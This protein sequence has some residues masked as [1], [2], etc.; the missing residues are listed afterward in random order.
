MA[1]VPYQ[2]G[3]QQIGASSYA[4]LQPD[5]SWG[6]SNAGLVVDGDQSLLV[7]TLFDLKMT[8]E[9]LSE[10]ADAVPA[11]RQIDILVN[12]HADCDHIYGNQLVSGARIVM[13]QAAALEFYKLPPERLRQIISDWQDYGAGGRYIHEHMGPRLFDFSEIVLTPPS[14]TFAREKRI[15]VG[16][17]NVVLTNVGPAHTA[18]DVLVHVI[19]DR[20]V[21]TGDLLFVGGHPAVWDGS[22]EGWVAACDHILSLDVEV[23]VPG[24]GPLT[25]KAGVARFREYLSMLI[26]ETRKRHDAGMALEDAAFDIAILPEFADWN[27]PE[28]IA[29]S[30]N[31]L[32]RQFGSEEATSDFIEIFARLD[33]Y[34]KRRAA[35]LAAKHIACGHE[36]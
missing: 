14:E 9:M 27:T 16:D 15:K 10:M 19:E 30:V 29:G 36:H 20:V 4:Y 31:F 7:D 34:A 18:G 22:I 6:W 28:R 24:H 12:T 3:L 32:Y 2:R 5:G 33:R 11:S 1:Q 26:E 35:Y 23:I 8:G 25:D 21:Y 13:S 17:K